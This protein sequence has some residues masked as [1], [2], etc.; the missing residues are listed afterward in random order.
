MSEVPQYT[1]G[2]SGPRSQA[3]RGPGWLVLMICIRNYYD[4]IFVDVEELVN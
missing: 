1:Q 4:S 2:L 3:G